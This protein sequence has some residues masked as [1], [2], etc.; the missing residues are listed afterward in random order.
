MP[1]GYTASVV[2]GKITDFNQFA[3]QC[4]RA[5]GA[6]ID[7]RDDPW[8]API[9]EELKPSDYNLKKLVEL[10]ERSAELQSMT[11]EQVRTAC[12]KD[13]TEACASRAQS[14][15]RDQL[16]N[17]RLD[18]IE[19]QV[20]AW[21]PPSANHAEMK[22]FMLYQIRISYHD[23][24]FHET[25]GLVKKRTPTDW[26]NEQLEKVQKDIGY[27][28]AEYEKEIERTNSKNLWIKQ[29]RE[30]LNEKVVV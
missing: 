18:Q 10:R 5:F 20:L 30:S 24:D 8:D 16:E 17:D 25:Y 11:A 12:E 3:L 4:A 6:L 28:A 22:T 2:D 14:K 19:K 27:H 29:L 13:Y 9:P 26:L 21:Q 7:M 23:I 15:A 1:T